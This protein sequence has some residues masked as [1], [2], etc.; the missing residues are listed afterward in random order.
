[1]TG[2]APLIDAASK[3]PNVLLIMADDLGYGDLS[4]HGN[5][6]LRTPNLDHF[7]AESIE[8][9]QFY[10]SPVCAPTR[11]SL[12]T[13][14]Y[15]Y[16]T[17]VQHTS[18]GGAL[19]D[20]SEVTM[21]EMLRTAGYTTGIFGKWHLGD[22]YPMRPVDQGF[23]ESLVFKGGMVSEPPD[24]PNSYFDTRLYRNG[25]PG[26]GE[27]YCS[28]VFTDETIRFIEANRERP[29]FAY[30]PFNVPHGPLVVDPKYSKPFDAMGL[31]ENVSKLYGMV[32]NLDENVGRLLTRLRELDLEQNT[33]VIF[34]SDNGGW[35]AV[36]R[37][38]AGLAGWKGSVEDGGIR[39]S[40]FFRWPAGVKGGRNVDRI[41]AHIDVLPT[42]LEATEVRKP[43]RVEFDGLSLMPLLRGHNVDWADRDLFFQ[44]HR[45]LIPQ[46]YQN[47]AVRSQRWKTLS[48]AN[49]ELQHDPK[50]LPLKPEFKLYDMLK[51]PGETMDL[52]KQYP[53]LVNKMK[54]A[55]EEWYEEMRQTRHWA[56]GVIH[57]GS[58]REPVTHLCVYQD[59]CYDMDKPTGWSVEIERSGHYRITI[60]R[61]NYPP[62]KLMIKLNNSVCSVPLEQ[63]ENSKVV[64]LP[65]GKGKLS[66]WVE[67]KKPTIGPGPTTNIG[68][69]DLEFLRV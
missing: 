21:A 6:Y 22:N 39:Q 23:D 4:C 25:K 58:E 18:R 12:M 43:E 55:Y 20:T 47:C 51:D 57:I 33:I 34:M 24:L 37:F 42:L 40:F 69:C 11:A 31:D 52:A 63:G 38:N 7:A 50:D 59:S 60:N 1:M 30:L 48:R 10:V 17:G 68:D 32:V 66:I 26:K 15:N 35:G 13:G 46:R 36:H 62:G 19:M 65:A 5:Q 14:R 64:K 44:F 41:A 28:D 29:F 67:Q 9:T 53:E 45:G 54:V 56:V 2:L 16:R 49:D 61:A 8:M 3:S 27:G